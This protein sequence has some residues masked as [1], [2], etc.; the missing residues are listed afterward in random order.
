MVIEYWVGTED[1]YQGPTAGT[2]RTAGTGG[3]TTASSRSRRAVWVWA[4]HRPRQRRRRPDVETTRKTEK[5]FES[6]GSLSCRQYCLL[7]VYSGL[8]AFSEPLETDTSDE[9]KIMGNRLKAFKR[10]TGSE[11]PTEKAVGVTFVRCAT[12]R[13][14]TSPL[15]WQSATLRKPA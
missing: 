2:A 14:N 10:L 11:R 4:H 7:R 6:Y 13:P 15:D 1:A 3:S 9:Q 8:W 12:E 5:T